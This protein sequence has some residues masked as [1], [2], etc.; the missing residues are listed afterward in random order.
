MTRTNKL[1]IFKLKPVKT[2]ISWAGWLASTHMKE[3]DYIVGDHFATPSIDDKNFSEKVYRVGDIWCTYSRSVFDDLRLK[4]N[5]NNNEDVNFGCFQRPEKINQ[6]IL[7]VWSK[8]LLRTKRSNIYFVNNSIGPYEKKIITDFL[9]KNKISL[10]RV[11]FISPQNREIYLNSFNLVDINLDTFPYNGG[12]TSFESTFM[13]IPTL[14]MKNNSFMFRCGESINKNLNMDNWIA[15]DEKDYIDKGVFF[16]N[17]KKLND[18]K[19]KLNN[20]NPHCVLFDSKKF[21][22]EFLEMI[23][24]IA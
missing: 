20:Q 21:S 4:K 22:N 23:L 11:F 15:D 14:T 24:K 10:S 2:Q 13:N 9:K 8:I 16:C 3:I 1:N 19:R 5:Q 12:T 6:K 17:K 18:I 7:K